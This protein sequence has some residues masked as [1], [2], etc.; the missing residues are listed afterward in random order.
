MHAKIEKKGNGFS[1][2]LP[3]ELIE[4][5]GFGQEVNVT[6]R[7]KTLVVASEDHSTIAGWDEAIRNIPQALIDRDFEELKT[8]REM[9]DPAG[10]YR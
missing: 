3:R 9:H 10:S 2:L 6:L 1:L 5:C 4:A 7:A 8:F